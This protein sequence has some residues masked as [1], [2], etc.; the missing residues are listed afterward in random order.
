MGLVDL[1]VSLVGRRDVTGQIYGQLRQAIVSGVLRPGDR[2]P[3]TRE[4]A[5]R[6]AVSRTTVT[7]AYDR[8]AGEGFLSSAWAPARSSATTSPTAGPEPGPPAGVLRPLPIW[9]RADAKRRGRSAATTS[10]SGAPIRRCSRS[11]SG[12]RW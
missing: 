5:T 4:L 2:L 11:S 10:A 8:L 9:D 6:L 1:H 3:P 7:V 12:G